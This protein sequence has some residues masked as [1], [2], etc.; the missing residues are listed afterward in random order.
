MTNTIQYDANVPLIS[1]SIAES[2]IDFLN[3]FKVLYDAFSRNHVALDA[4]LSAGNHTTI[5]L[6]EQISQFQTDVGEIS[7][8]SKEVIHQTSQIILKYQGTSEEFQFTNYQLYSLKQ[9]SKQTQFFTILPG[10]VIVYFGTI[11]VSINKFDKK[12]NPIPATLNLLPSISKNI[13]TINLCQDGTANL[14]EGITP[15]VDLVPQTKEGIYSTINLYNSFPSIPINNI[16]Y[17]Y[18][19]LGNII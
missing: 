3:N 18:I 2:Q 14:N 10:K 11:I 12:N 4:A 13:I 5:E 16:K 7:I 1:D 19:V 17:N 6:P 9:T 15:N 8:Y